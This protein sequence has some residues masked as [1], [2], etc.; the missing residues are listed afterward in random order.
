MSNIG[1]Y[2]NNILKAVYGKEVRQSIHD[3]ISQCYDDVNN[4][5]LNTGAFEKAVQ[6]KID[7]GEMAAL[8]LADESVTSKKLASGAVTREKLETGFESELIDIRSLDTLKKL[9]DTIFAQQWI[10]N[11]YLASG[12]F[13][14][15]NFN[16]K[17][18]L[19]KDTHFFSVPWGFHN[20][21]EADELYGFYNYIS[22]GGTMNIR[23]SNYH[24]LEPGTY[25]Y[26][27]QFGTSGSASNS[28]DVQFICSTQSDIVS[29]YNKYLDDPKSSTFA[30]LN[31]ID[32]TEPIKT[33]IYTS[34][35]YKVRLYQFTV[36][37]G[38]Y[39]YLAVR[40]TYRNST[41]ADSFSNELVKLSHISKV[42][43]NA[44]FSETYP[45]TF[46]EQTYYYF[47][48]TTLGKMLMHGLSEM[49]SNNTESTQ[50]SGY[51]INTY[52]KTYVLVGDSG[53]SYGAADI[54]KAIK[55]RC[56]CVGSVKSVAGTKFS[57]TVNGGGLWF[58]N[59]YH[60]SGYPDIV[61]LCWGGNFDSGGVGSIT[62]DYI[63]DDT[64]TPTTTLG[65]L[66]C[67]IEDIRTVSPNTCIIGW[68]PYQMNLDGSYE[69][70]KVVYEQIREAYGK[71]AIPIVDAF[72]ES[73]IVPR[74]MM[75]FD[76][77]GIGSDSGHPS[78]Y[79]R[80]R[81]AKLIANTIIRYV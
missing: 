35:Y 8:A 28:E 17:L 5:D 27:A 33:E 80:K 14:W 66:R 23:Y 43:I 41:A 72:Y 2:L 79:G 24:G 64:N 40:S 13:T 57:D 37:D 36:P 39:G 53:T 21:A 46:D 68:I 67:I 42:M 52:G 7:S 38:M 47:G 22:N 65:A 62:E 70:R 26:I 60:D 61:V 49:F 73:G 45:L 58:Y 63:Y 56:G 15:D 29:A 44:D 34:G 6:N 50:N 18:E 48:K 77:G 11:I 55:E 12:Q 31:G 76:G 74:D 81:I 3:A 59:Q 30:T 10:I 78:A 16:E 25:Y 20:P 69:N 4:P 51:P 1:T 32:Y 9:P 75:G 71:L 19:Y 54:E